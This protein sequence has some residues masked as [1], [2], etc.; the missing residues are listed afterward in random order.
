[1]NSTKN[2]NTA[3]QLR[4]QAS[5]AGED[6]LATSLSDKMGVLNSQTKIQKR[7]FMPDKEKQNK[8]KSQIALQKHQQFISGKN[9]WKSEGNRSNDGGIVKAKINLMPLKKKDLTDDFGLEGS[10]D[11]QFDQQMLYLREPSVPSLQGKGK[12]SFIFDSIFEVSLERNLHKGNS[13]MDHSFDG[14]EG[15]LLEGNSDQDSLKFSSMTQLSFITSREEGDMRL[16]STVNVKVSPKDMTAL[17]SRRNM[18]ARKINS[19]LETEKK[20]SV[21][22]ETYNRVVS[23]VDKHGDIS[24]ERL[25]EA[26]FPKGRIPNFKAMCNFRLIETRLLNIV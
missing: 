6:N 5:E 10:E 19:Q 8:F 20:L 1:M 23:S 22:T 7:S 13:R 17:K 21:D 16:S 18:A 26:F 4:T 9:K 3:H 2:Y 11:S 12:G 15:S 24:Y 25:Y 14:F